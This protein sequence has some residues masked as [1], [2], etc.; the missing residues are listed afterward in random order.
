MPEEREPTYLAADLFAGIGG[1][2]LGFEG[3][4]NDRIRTVFVCEI[5]GKAQETYNARFHQDHIHGDITTVD[6]RR[7]KKFHICLAGFPCQAFSMAGKRGGFEDNHN[8]INRGKLFFEVTRICKS[9]KPMVIFCE[10]VKGLAHH[11]GG[12]TLEKMEDELRSI[13]YVVKSDVLNSKDFGVPHNRERLYIVAFRKDIDISGFSFPKPLGKE[14]TIGDI[15]EKGVVD[16]KYYLSS[17]YMNTL[18]RHKKRQ[19]SRGNG[20]GYVLR[21]RH[22]IAGALVGGG[23]GKE[24]NLI[25]DRKRKTFEPA[26]GIRGEVNKGQIRRLTPHECA[27]L[28]GFPDDFPLVVADTHLYSQFSNSVT[29][30]VVEAIAE[31]IKKI[32]DKHLANGGSIYYKG[33]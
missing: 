3:A 12:K 33:R 27:R 10:N 26:A 5:D 20:F 21:Y 28:Q 29:V 15:L 4:F 18:R 17:R 9:K 7:V 2:R 8:G 31:E 6:I 14:T 25:I 30:P 11:N 32:L 19:K 13:D 1:I 22:D 16:A 23:M 24:R